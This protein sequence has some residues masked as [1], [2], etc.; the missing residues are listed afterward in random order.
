MAAIE[1]IAENDGPMGDIT[2][3]QSCVEGDWLAMQVFRESRVESMELI[4]GFDYGRSLEEQDRTPVNTMLRLLLVLRQRLVAN[5]PT[6]DVYSIYQ[7]LRKTMS[8]MQK[9]LRI[10]S[11]NMRL[12]SWMERAASEAIVSG[13][14]VLYMG[15]D[16]PFGP[17]SYRPWVGDVPY[18]KLVTLDDF[19]VDM[20][21]EDLEDITYIGHWF[22]IPAPLLAQSGFFR[23][24]D[25]L[26]AVKP[27]VRTARNPDGS[28]RGRGLS[29]DDTADSTEYMPHVSLFHC[30]LPFE[31]K[32]CIFAA[33][34][35]PGSFEGEPII[36]R[37]W[38]G[39]GRNCTGPYHILRYIEI[40]QNLL[41]LPLVSLVKDLHIAKRDLTNKILTR[42]LDEKDL[43]ITEAGNEKDSD[44]IRDAEDMSVVSLQKLPPDPKPVHLGGVNQP[45]IAVNMIADE[46]INKMSFNLEALSGTGRSADT[47]RQEGMI[48]AAA[49]VQVSDFEK[50][51]YKFGDNLV[52]GISWYMMHD[53]N[54]AITVYYELDGIP[55]PSVLYSRELE[56]HYDKMNF[57]IRLGSLQ[58]K[59]NAVLAEE[60]KDLFMGVV[61]PMAPILAQ[62]G[63]APNVREFL[64]E[65]ARLTGREGHLNSLIMTGVPLFTEQPEMSMAPMRIPGQKPATAPRTN[66]GPTGKGFRQNMMAYALGGEG[67]SIGGA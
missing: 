64:K 32:V 29:S 35:G 62:T 67:A 19:I 10:V 43:F 14:G 55:Y 5:N 8:K 23:N 38:D 21:S 12:E 57:S 17:R 9:A 31:G 50:K 20:R 47:A 60:L 65:Y 37:E 2:A 51:T 6:I 52:D 4:K 40:E 45:S 27:Y 1:P 61:V 24:S 46:E 25:E 3:L 59:T 49:N 56:G 33:P 13:T 53:P 41:G 26:D 42:T 30:Y 16:S 22:R 15:V 7:S 34:D 48:S 36:T 39:S 63:E 58:P 11:E 54:F 28:W 66:T 18:L 44:M